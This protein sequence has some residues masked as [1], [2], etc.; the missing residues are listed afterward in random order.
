MSA[1]LLLGTLQKFKDQV[2]ADVFVETGTYDGRGVQFALMC[3][4]KEIHSIE[5]DPQRY[6][7]CAVMYMPFMDVHI[8][9][10]DT[11]ELLGPLL[12]RITKRAVIWLDAHPIGS[13]DS[14]PRGLAE[15]PLMGELA[16]IKQMSLLK[17]HTLLI[18]DRDCFS[19]LFGT[20]DTQV[21]D[22]ILEINQK[23]EFTFEPNAMFPTDIL[24]AEVKS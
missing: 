9:H 12:S 21:K 23:Y 7:D 22:A 14:C 16:I 1:I 20:S 17:D 3:G 2:K 24:T 4:F 18:D 5:I 19:K 15:W 13:G 6:K 10:G 8:Y 11:L